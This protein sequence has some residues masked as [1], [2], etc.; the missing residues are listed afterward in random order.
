MKTTDHHIQDLIVGYLANELTAPQ[1]Q[2]LRTWI[3]AAPENETYF[4]AWRE[5]WFSADAASL[6]RYDSQKAFALFKQRMA[7]EASML[8][9]KRHRRRLWYAAASI[10]ALLVVSSLV[11]VGWT[12]RTLRTVADVVIETPVGSRMK[13][14]LPDGTTVWLNAQSKITYSQHFGIEDRHVRLSGE[15]Y[16]EVKE[17]KALP[18]IV[19]SKH[20]KVRDLGTKFNFKD[21]P[22]DERSIVSL[23][24]GEIALSSLVRQDGDMILVPGQQAV[25]EKPSGKVSVANAPVEASTQWVAGIITFNGEKL[26]EVVKD[27]ERYYGVVISF[28]GDRVA[29]R[30]FFGTFNPQEQSLHD[31][32]DAFAATGKLRYKSHGR[33]VIIY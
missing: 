32:L 3:S 10:A 27:L 21:Y 31:I 12:N 16:F 8:S 26:G 15:G 29:R 6:D 20:L 22:G 2:E 19:E 24:E 18:F 7:D 13:L 30:R 4:N 33:K 1:E 9:R 17:N 11:Y 25:L 28:E 14:T 23:T 5:V